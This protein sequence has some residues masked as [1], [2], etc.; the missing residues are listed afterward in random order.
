M[1]KF[2]HLE[3]RQEIDELHIPTGRAVRLFMASEDVIH[4]FYVPAFRTKMDVVPGRYTQMW[5][6]A[7]KPGEYP[8]YC[9]EYCGTL[10]SG[11]IGRVIALEPLERGVSGRVAKLRVR[12]ER[13]SATIVG[14]LRIRR[15]LGGLKSTLF[16]VAT[17]GPSTAPTAFVLHGAGFG[18]GV[19]MCQ[20]GA[21]GMAERRSSLQQILAHYFPGATIHALY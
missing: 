4:S 11:M 13:G 16:S 17:E 2:Q 14:D 8:L 7:T 1:W 6:E 19:G 9:A 15:T 20:V 12:G 3:G 5:F 10:H 21:I 18:H